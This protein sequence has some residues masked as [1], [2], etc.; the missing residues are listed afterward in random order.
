MIKLFIRFVKWFNLKIINMKKIFKI[1]LVICLPILLS[2][3]SNDDNNETNST[4]KTKV[5]ISK[6]WV[7]TIPSTN[8]S[9]SW[10]VASAPDIY[11]EITDRD[12]AGLRATTVWDFMPSPNTPYQV[13]FIPQIETTDFTETLDVD[14]WDDDSDNGTSDDYIG[15]V[16]FRISDYTTGSD[17]YP[18]SAIKSNNGTVVT[19]F[20]TWE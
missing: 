14:V 19:V 11:T 1:L 16:Q 17:R 15:N 3:C 9:L 7:T 2:S 8:G 10:D 6:I 20:F 18:S 13:T 12:G 5:K 4:T